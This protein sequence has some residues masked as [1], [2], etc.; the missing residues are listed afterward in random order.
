MTESRPANNYL[1]MILLEINKIIIMFLPNGKKI[2][3][4]ISKII[5][6]RQLNSLKN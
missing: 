4:A 5:L 6:L 3:L 1:V 2:L